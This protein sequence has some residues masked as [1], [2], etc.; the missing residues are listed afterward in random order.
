MLDLMPAERDESFLAVELGT[1]AGWLSAAVLERFPASRILGLDGSSTML[2][3]TAK[4]LQPFGGRFELDQFKL[5]VASWAEKINEPVRCFFSSLVVHH[6]DGPGKR[7]LYGRLYE[8]LEPGGAV[9]ICD[10]VAPRSERERRA[11]ATA[12]DREVERQSLAMTGSLNAYQQFLDDQWNWYRYP[13]P[14]DKPSSVPEHLRWLEEAGFE[15]AN[16][17][18]ERAAHAIYGGYRE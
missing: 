8:R 3:E 5:E 2:E 7:D 15:G 14:F 9:L 18:W 10:L 6:L 1:G 11:L 4:T 13:D 17:F 16:V 12:W